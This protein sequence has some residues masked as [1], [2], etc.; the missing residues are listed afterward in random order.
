MTLLATLNKFSSIRQN[1]QI[2]HAYT[3]WNIHWNFRWWEERDGRCRITSNQTRLNAEITLPRLSTAD[4]ATRRRFDL[5]LLALRAHEMEHV[6]IARD[7]AQR[8]DAGILRLPQMPSCAA[9]TRAANALGDELLRQAVHAE[10][11]MDQRT[12]HGARQGASLL[13]D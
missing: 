6:R 8:I 7:Y 2:F 4:T 5:Y 11:D 13:N 1:G 12:A 9:L 10:R 3:A